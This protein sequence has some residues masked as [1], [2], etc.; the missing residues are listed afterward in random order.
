MFILWSCGSELF[1]EHLCD[2]DDVVPEPRPDDR[3]T[4]VLI[5]DLGQRVHAAGGEVLHL[6]VI[7]LEVAQ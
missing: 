5:H 1:V 4:I 2:L 3:F 7:C 6:P